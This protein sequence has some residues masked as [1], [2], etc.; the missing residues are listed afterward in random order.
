MC[1]SNHL[2][3]TITKNYFH[4]YLMAA[5]LYFLSLFLWW[6]FFF[7]RAAL[8]FGN[9]KMQRFNLHLIKFISKHAKG[10]AYKPGKGMME[11]KKKS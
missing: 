5:I 6:I 8:Y 7:N 1:A 9:I 11:V 2:K 10:I 4:K 3:I